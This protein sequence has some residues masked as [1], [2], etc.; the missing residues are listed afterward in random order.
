[1]EALLNNP[2]CTYI[3]GIVTAIILDL[4]IYSISKK[5]KK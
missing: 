2:G 4:V 5:I 1:M 3:L